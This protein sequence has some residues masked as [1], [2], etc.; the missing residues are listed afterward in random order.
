MYPLTDKRIEE[1]EVYLRANP[2]SILFARLADCLLES[3]KVD[4]AIEI[5]E[6]G[7]KKH[8]YYVT[9]HFVM[10]KCYLKKELHD[11]AEKE[12]K[13]VLFLDPKYLAAHKLYADI[14]HKTGWENAVETSY[15]KILEID[16]L[17]TK[18]R[19]KLNE[20]QAAKETKPESQFQDNPPFETVKEEDIFTESTTP[21]EEELMPAEDTFQKTIPDELPEETIPDKLL[22]EEE[23]EPI[24]E[25]EEE[26]FSSIIDE[27]FEEDMA[28]DEETLEKD[29]SEEKDFD[30]DFDHEAQ[31]KSESEVPDT[32]LFEEPIDLEETFKFSTEEKKPETHSQEKAKS[33]PKE[34][35]QP[36]IEDEAKLQSESKKTSD[37]QVEPK[38]RPS[39]AFLEASDDQLFPVQTE[40]EF[41]PSSPRKKGK[42]VTPT[43]GEIYAA[44]GQYAKAIGVFEILRKK[45]PNNK[46]YIEKLEY[47]K[48]KLEESRLQ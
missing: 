12:L 2:N 39:P 31:K 8:P 48:R 11:Q 16:P 41:I 38:Q 37:E 19:S 20:L 6:E 25:N 36:T 42:I 15:E 21:V 29:A 10:G 35:T 26:K 13:R 45:E 24:T 5:C 23:A 22:E 30:F 1:L 4:Q 27:I 43:L 34:N 14:M 18:I 33:P 40:P 32:S 47:L 3:G 9:G 46:A 17:N 28:L 7:L 44:Q